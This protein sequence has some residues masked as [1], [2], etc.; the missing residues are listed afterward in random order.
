MAGGNFKNRTLIYEKMAHTAT[1]N[2][3]SKVIFMVHEYNG[4]QC[5]LG[6]IV[7]FQTGITLL[8]GELDAIGIYG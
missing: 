3:I 5:K 8:S 6:G 7:S 2:E 1:S 4:L